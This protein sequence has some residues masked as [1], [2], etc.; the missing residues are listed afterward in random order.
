MSVFKFSKVDC[1]LTYVGLTVLILDIGLDIYTAWS[2]YQEEDYVYLGILIALLVGSSMLCQVYSWLWYSYDKNGSMVTKVQEAVSPGLLKVVHFLQLGV[3]FR[4]ATVVDITTC[5]CITKSP[6]REDLAVYAIH[7][8]SLLRLFEAFSESAPQMVLL[9]TSML[10]RGQTDYLTA[11]K[12]LASASAIA[13]TVTTYHRCL[14]SFLPEKA[15][16]SVFSSCVYFIWNL[17]LIFSR[18]SAIAVFA[19]VQPCFI[20]PHF[21]CYWMLFFFC[22]WRCKSTLM[23]SSAGEWF[24]RATAAFIWYFTWFNIVEGKTRYNT[25]CYHSL[26]LLDT[27]MLCGLWFWRTNTQTAL[28]VL[29]SIILFYIAGLILKITYYKFFHPNLDKHELRAAEEMVSVSSENSDDVA[30]RR[31]L[32]EDVVDGIVA[33]DDGSRSDGKMRKRTENYNKRM[34]KLAENFYS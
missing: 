18:L 22:A 17:L 11:L 28:I 31:F 14:R 24:Y 4:H 26:M 27:G 21:I 33:R 10:R 34:R 13:L 20:F 2:F 5:S 15:K 3:Y 7:D 25:L 19:S 30:E 1:F 12:A 6:I 16:Q 9:L 29:L 32:N 8:L 23:D